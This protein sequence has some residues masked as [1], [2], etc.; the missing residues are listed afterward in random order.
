M[1]IDCLVSGLS[2]CVSVLTAGSFCFLFECI[3]EKGRVMSYVDFGCF[4]FSYRL[5]E[6]VFHVCWMVKAWT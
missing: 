4:L 3:G 1:I 6:N 2:G 5:V